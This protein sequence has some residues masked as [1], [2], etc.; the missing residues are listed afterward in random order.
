VPQGDPFFTETDAFVAELNS[1]ATDTAWTFTYPARTTKS[2]RGNDGSDVGYTNQECLYAIVPAPD[3]GYTISGNNSSNFDDDY[4]VKFKAS[5]SQAVDTTTVVH[6]HVY[7]FGPDDL[8]IGP[9]FVGESSSY[10]EFV[11]RNSIS[12]DGPFEMEAGS[13]FEADIDGDFIGVTFRLEGVARP[14]VLVESAKVYLAD[15]EQASVHDFGLDANYP[16]PFNPVTQIRFSLPIERYVKLAVFD[17]L[18]REVARLIDR[19]LEAGEH[20]VIF[21]ASGLASGTYL[22]RLEAGRFTRTE[23]MTVIK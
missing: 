2:H 15:E 18:G 17:A 6:A 13:V 9:Y 1:T 16:N 20:R 14:P 22:Y 21:D 7:Y 19:K 8:T 12:I 3:G 11:A 10:V 23:T 4:V 5:S